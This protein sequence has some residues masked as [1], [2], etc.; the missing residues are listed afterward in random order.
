MSTYNLYFK[1]AINQS[2]KM[3]CALTITGLSS[4]CLVAQAENNN[5][6][7]SQNQSGHQAFDYNYAELS[8]FDVELDRDSN[9]DVDTDGFALKGSYRLPGDNSDWFI[10]G[11]YSD[12]EFDGNNA[13]GSQ[14]E[15]GAGY[16][17]ERDRGYDLFGTVSFIRQEVE[18]NN[19]DDSET[20][21][22]LGAG[23]RKMVNQDVELRGTANFQDVD[24]N[25]F[26]LELEGDYFI[27]EEFVG[28]LTLSL[29]DVSGF[30]LRGRYYF[31]K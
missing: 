5:R 29:G 9:N 28:G 31:D 19:T 22:G 6:Y 16:I 3:L 17:S 8:F 23:I 14:L 11:G 18:F 1:P 20:G 13:D 2:K 12:Y 24:D 21:F 4:Y 25:A 27:T 26:F 15:I 30:T 10:H 7:Y